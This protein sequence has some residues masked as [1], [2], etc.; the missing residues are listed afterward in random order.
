MNAIRK[1]LSIKNIRF[2]FVIKKKK[3]HKLQ[4]WPELSLI[5]DPIFAISFLYPNNNSISK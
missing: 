4:L 1:K 3:N 5:E 2:K